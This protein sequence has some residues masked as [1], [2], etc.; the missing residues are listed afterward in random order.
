MN[1]PRLAAWPARRWGA[2]GL[3]VALFA[4]VVLLIH[5][6]HREFLAKTRDDGLSHVTPEQVRPYFPNAFSLVPSVEIADARDVLDESGRRLGHILQTSPAGDASIGFSGPTNV[7]IACDEKLTILGLTILASR[8]TR[9]HVRRVKTDQ[10]FLVGY[11]GLTLA[12]AAQRTNVDVVSGATLTSDAIA[13]AIIRRLGGTAASL[14]FADP[15]TVADVKPLF[16]AAEAVEPD[17]GEPTV[18]RVTDGQHRPLGWAL[19]TSPAADNI[20]GYQGPTDTLIGFDTAGRV[21][22]L[23]IRKSYDNQPYVGFRDDDYFNK[24]FNGKTLGELA[25][26]NLEA[27]GV[28]GVSGAT[29]TSMAVARGLLAA[30]NKQLA[31]RAVPKPQSFW[32]S[33]SASDWGTC[34]VILA[35][36]IVGLTNLRGNRWVRIALPL[37]MLVYLGFV[38]G[39]LLSQAQLVGWAQSGVS[40]GAAGLAALTGAALLLPIVTKRNVYCTHLCPHG[41][42]QQLIKLT[43]RPRFALRRP[44]RWAF[45]AVPAIL[46]AVSVTVALTHWP[47]SLV[48]IEPF[49]AYVVRIAGYWTLG[50]AV[51]GLLAACFV[52]MA[53]CRFGCPTGALLEYLRRNARSHR[54][55]RRDAVAVALLALAVVLWKLG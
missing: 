7:L 19:R 52:P 48:D 40:H 32:A 25:N 53:Y 35:G 36:V 21:I 3:R 38:N 24:Y 27:A 20:I 6:K 2:H 41:A 51:V 17:H 44:W 33:I 54:F 55:S 23:A 8:D 12:E 30:A 29:M 39:A 11:Q 46:L 49:D 18:I 50:I 15:I 31:E 47:L 14:K 34:G 42:A 45:V 13:E 16:P 9:E 43:V 10:H 1:A 28:E 26:T 37:V 4:G 22:G 5:A